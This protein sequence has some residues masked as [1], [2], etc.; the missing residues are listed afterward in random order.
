MQQCV[1]T[2]TTCN[3]HP[4]MLRLLAQSLR[5]TLKIGYMESSKAQASPIN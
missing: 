5:L 2:E 4:T 1:Q 3:T